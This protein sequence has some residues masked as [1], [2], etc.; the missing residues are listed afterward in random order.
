MHIFQLYCSAGW[1]DEDWS[2]EQV[3]LD[4]EWYMMDEGHGEA[5]NP[6]NDVPQEYID[7]REQQL[8]ARRVRLFLGYFFE[9]LILEAY[10]FTSPWI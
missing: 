6:F 8:E 10:L 2:A 1:D 3:R 4:R 9:I 7:K 5:D